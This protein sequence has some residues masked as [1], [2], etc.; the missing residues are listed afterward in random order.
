M[1]VALACRSGGSTTKRL[2]SQMPAALGGSVSPNNCRNT[3]D[4]MYGRV[5]GSS[6]QAPMTRLVSS[7]TMR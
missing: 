5:V 2:H 4:A 7:E 6:R 3:D 1:P